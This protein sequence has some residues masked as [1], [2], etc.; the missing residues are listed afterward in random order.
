MDFDKITF[1][2]NKTTKKYKMKIVE[3][4]IEQLT[5]EIQQSPLR[6]DLVG[7]L[8]DYRNRYT[9]LEL[10]RRQGNDL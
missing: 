4:L 9:S 8:K 6:E 1:I 2:A 7:M 5:P 3:R 10:Q